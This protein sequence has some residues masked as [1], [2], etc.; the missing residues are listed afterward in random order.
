MLFALNI[1]RR[2]GWYLRFLLSVITLFD[3]YGSIISWES[4][5]CIFDRK[6]SH[7]SAWCSSASDLCDYL[8]WWALHFSSSAARQK[9]EHCDVCSL[10]QG[11]WTNTCHPGS[12]SP[13]SMSRTH[14]ARQLQITSFIQLGTRHLGQPPLVRLFLDTSWNCDRFTMG[15]RWPRIFK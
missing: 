7:E 4:W 1:Q 12:V 14:P 5:F 9:G 6:K 8:G 11:A 10:F 15:L 3:N 13:L 2:H